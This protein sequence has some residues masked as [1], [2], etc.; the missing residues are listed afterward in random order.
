ML[1][2]GWDESALEVLNNIRKSLRNSVIVLLRLLL[3]EKMGPLFGGQPCSAFKN[4]C[5]SRLA[6]SEQSVGSFAVPH[7]L[8]ETI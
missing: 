7:R 4:C 1:E 5:V 2:T 8:Q 3:A 6:T